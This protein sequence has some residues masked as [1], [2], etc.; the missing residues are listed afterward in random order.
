MKTPPELNDEAQ[1]MRDKVIAEATKYLEDKIRI[2]ML[3]DKL[4]VTIPVIHAL[5]CAKSGMAQV[6]KKAGYRCEPS[7]SSWV[8]RW[9]KKDLT[10]KPK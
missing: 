8:I 10:K 5:E 6:V 7:S 4:V 2:A 9:T 3:E 1:A